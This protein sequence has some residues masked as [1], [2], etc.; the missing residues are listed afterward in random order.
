MGERIGSREVGNTSQ[1]L[2]HAPECVLALDS[3][4]KPPND[5]P[6]MRHFEKYIAVSFEAGSD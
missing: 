3:Q 1:G 5:L 4:S 6:S 2:Q